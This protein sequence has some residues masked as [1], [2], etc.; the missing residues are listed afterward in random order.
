MDMRKQETLSKTVLHC[1]AGVPPAPS[2]FAESEGTPPP[3]M[4][5]ENLIP[6]KIH[7]NGWKMVS[8]YKIWLN[9]DPKGLAIDEKG[10]RIDEKG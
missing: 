4:L 7:S 8:V 2:F 5:S 1:S 3:P 9:M 6:E 10:Q